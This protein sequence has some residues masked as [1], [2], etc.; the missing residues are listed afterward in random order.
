MY[1]RLGMGAWEAVELAPSNAGS[2]QSKEVS[3][4][5]KTLIVAVLSENRSDPR[6]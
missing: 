3:H 5:G 6:R 4:D 2:R 1:F